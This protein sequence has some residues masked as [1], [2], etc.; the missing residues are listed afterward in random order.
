M[1]MED[2][3]QEIEVVVE[4]TGLPY[5]WLDRST[6][7]KG[8]QLW[9]PE[10]V[11]NRRVAVTGDQVYWAVGPKDVVFMS[12]E[13]DVFVEE[14]VY[15]SMGSMVVAEGGETAVPARSVWDERETAAGGVRSGAVDANPRRIQPSAGHRAVYG[16][17]AAAERS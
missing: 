7:R 3:R 16:A 5:S 14:A 8:N 6:L 12:R 9:L 11:L 10:R 2:V 1:G 15:V 17:T 4:L 13:N